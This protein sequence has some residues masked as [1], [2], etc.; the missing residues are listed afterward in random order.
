LEFLRRSLAVLRPPPRPRSTP[1]GFLV[2]FISYQCLAF[3]AAVK[4]R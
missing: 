1:L 2:G 4:A 3:L